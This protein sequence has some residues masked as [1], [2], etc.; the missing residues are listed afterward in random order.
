MEVSFYFSITAIL[1]SLASLG[2]S[3]HIGNRDKGKLLV[4][5]KLYNIDSGP[6]IRIKAVNYGRRPIILTTLW[7]CYPDK[8]ASGTMLQEKRLNE[9]EQFE[10]DIN[11]HDLVYFDDEGNEKEVIDYYL[12]DTIGRTYKVKNIKENLKTIKS[13]R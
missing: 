1:I 5:S 8:T 13:K 12:E 11:E 2:W 10:R 4:K 7:A 6:F 3:I 9:N